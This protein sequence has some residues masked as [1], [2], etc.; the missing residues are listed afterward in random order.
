MVNDN[1]IILYYYPGTQKTCFVSHVA[2]WDGVYFISFPEEIV[3]LINP[4]ARAKAYEKRHGLYRKLILP[5]PK[6]FSS[7]R[8]KL[9]DDLCENYFR[10]KYSVIS[11][12]CADALSAYLSD[13]GY[14]KMQGCCLHPRIPT[15][16]AN[17]ACKEGKKMALLFVEQEE[18]L[19]RLSG[20][21]KLMLKIFAELTTALDGKDVRCRLRTFQKPSGVKELS[22]ILQK[23]MDVEKKFFKL[24]RKLID[25]HY[26]SKPFFRTIYIDR[27]YAGMLIKM[28]DF[29]KQRQIP[30]SCIWRQPIEIK[31]QPSMFSIRG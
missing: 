7:Q 6:H 13:I 28:Y 15:D 14:E 20:E 22:Q 5:V 1:Y 27:L 3:R 29:C 18:K 21:R 23:D 19:S 30:E 25:L 31:P 24:F 12:N 17:E 11:R 10:Q 26:Q 4:D 9:T 8:E 16:V 2:M